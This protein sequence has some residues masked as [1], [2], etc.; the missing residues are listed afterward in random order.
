MAEKLFWLY[1]KTGG[2]ASARNIIAVFN[3]DEAFDINEEYLAREVTTSTV[4]NFST[5]VIAVDFG[6]SETINAFTYNETTGV[7]SGPGGIAVLTI[8]LRQNRM[9]GELDFLVDAVSWTQ[10]LDSKLTSAKREEYRL[11]IEQLNSINVVGSIH[12]QSIWATNPEAIV[13]PTAPGQT[14]TNT[15][16]AYRAG[17][18]M[19]DS[20]IPV[21]KQFVSNRGNL[22]PE[23]D[24]EDADADLFVIRAGLRD[25]NGNVTQYV[26]VTP[27]FV[28]SAQS[29]SVAMRVVVPSGKNVL[30]IF[31]KPINF[32]AMR[33][34]ARYYNVTA[35]YNGQSGTDGVVTSVYVEAGVRAHSATKTQWVNN[36]MLSAFEQFDN[37]PDAISDGVMGR[38]RSSTTAR[39][40]TG[41]INVRTANGANFPNG[42]TFTVDDLT[43]IQAVNPDGIAPGAIKEEHIIRGEV[44]NFKHVQSTVAVGGITNSFA[45]HPDW[46]QAIA[47]ADMPLD[48]TMPVKVDAFCHIGTAG[49]TRGV[50]AFAI[51]KQTNQNGVISSETLLTNA[52]MHIPPNESDIIS[53]TAIDT[54]PVTNVLNATVT[55]RLRVTRAINVTG[56]MNTF[57]TYDRNMSAVQMK[58]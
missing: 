52:S 6:D 8:E 2:S 55:Y 51:T 26:N 35:A 9:R 13:R 58:V 3:E 39:W 42:F 31:G 53:I 49:G 38:V 44:S 12:Y 18:L 5:D 36:S 25:V 50:L 43:I 29:G 40:G 20:T 37:T 17:E 10:R 28:T 27:T 41:Y 34:E 22:A 30:E 57:A 19:G 14:F 48:S 46:Y 21:R 7:L 4:G 47:L 1:N 45:G 23:F 24:M 11:Y 32:F 33:G 54:T 15:D 56:Q 16:Q